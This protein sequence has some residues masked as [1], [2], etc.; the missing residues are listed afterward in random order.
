MQH[1]SQSFFQIY[2]RAINQR[3]R[4]DLLVGLNCFA[5]SVR[6]KFHAIKWAEQSKQ[7]ATDNFGGSC[8]SAEP[9]DLDTNLHPTN[10]WTP[11]NT[12]PACR[13][14]EVILIEIE[15]ERLDHLDKM[16]VKDTR[17][18]TLNNIE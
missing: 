10:R 11:D 12:S 4:T 18:K 16:A 1:N 9:Q 8:P 7:N 6:K 17:K 3:V 2:N 5:N 15:K 14:V 13:E